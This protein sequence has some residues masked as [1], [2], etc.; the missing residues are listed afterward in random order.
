[1]A[2][3]DD[4]VGVISADIPIRTRLLKSTQEWYSSIVQYHPYKKLTLTVV[5]EPCQ[6]GMVV[7]SG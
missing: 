1:M 2:S 7:D 6:L 5:T 3:G 4:M